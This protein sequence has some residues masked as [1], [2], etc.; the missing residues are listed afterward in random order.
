MD[1]NP[2]WKVFATECRDFVLE[3]IEPLRAL[4]RWIRSRRQ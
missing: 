4:I 3:C 1:H 2:L